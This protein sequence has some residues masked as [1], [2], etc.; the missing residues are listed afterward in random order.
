M[1]IFSSISP[2]P[3]WLNLNE[4]RIKLLFNPRPMSL[5]YTNGDGSC[6]TLKICLPFITIIQKVLSILGNK[7]NT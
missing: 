5:T 1:R 6:I 2:R 4:D 3:T 7:E